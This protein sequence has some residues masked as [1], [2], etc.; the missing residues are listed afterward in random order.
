MRLILIAGPIFVVFAII[1]YYLLI[2]TTP[3]NRR[4]K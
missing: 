1:E 4:D 2:F 3:H